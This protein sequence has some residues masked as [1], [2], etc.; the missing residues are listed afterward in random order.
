MEPVSSSETRISREKSSP[1]AEYCLDGRKPYDCISGRYFAYPDA[2]W[3]IDTT[4]DV[5]IKVDAAH[6]Q[7]KINIMDVDPDQ[8]TARV[9]LCHFGHDTTTLKMHLVFTQWQY[10]QGKA[11]EG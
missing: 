8:I 11:M 10:Q 4:K 9:D 1:S 2:G 5:E 6:G 3:E 7:Y